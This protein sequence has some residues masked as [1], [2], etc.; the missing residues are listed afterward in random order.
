MLAADAAARGATLRRRGPGTKH[1]EAVG[2]ATENQHA[3]GHGHAGRLPRGARHAEPSKSQEDPHC[4][5][6]RQRRL[7]PKCCWYLQLLLQRKMHA[8]PTRNHSTPSTP[9]QPTRSSHSESP[10]MSGAPAPERA[11]T[12]SKPRLTPCRQALVGCSGAHFSF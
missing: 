9:A 11:N 3:C 1:H 4:G 12:Q 7:E 6:L 2:E 8:H 5:S 10:G